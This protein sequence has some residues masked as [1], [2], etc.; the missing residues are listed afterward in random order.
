MIALRAIRVNKLRSILTTLGIIIGIVSVTAM[1]TVVNGIEN[2]FEEDMAELGTDVI[3]IERWP[4]VGGP[5]IKWWE[6]IN[7]PNITADL[8]RAVERRSKLAVAAA[9]VVRTSRTVRFG[10]RILNSV[11]I[12]GSTV[13]YPLVHTVDLASGFFYTAFDDRSARNV[14]VIGAGIADRLFPVEEP[15]GKVIS[16]SGSRYQVIGVMVRKGSGAEGPS[17]VDLEVKI[18]FNTFKKQFGTSR[19]DVSVQVKVANATLIEEAKD[20]LTGILRVARG[21]DAREDDDF[22][23]NEQQ[24]LRAQLAP[25]KAVIYSI[26]IGLT[27]LALLVGGIGVM[28]IMFVSVKERTREIGIRKAVGA[29]R[30]TILAQFLIEAV[31][32]CMVGGVVGVLLSLPITLLVQMIL[33]ATIDA[34]VVALAFGICVAIGTIFG[35]APAWTAAKAEP[36]QALRYE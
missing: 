11:T 6:Y 27:A 32:V 12:Q 7:R 23:I 34:G 17:G 19:R 14:C 20:E 22:T 25:I 8:A 26:G 21:L 31:V 3:Y 15:L 10:S 29:K 13:A 18:P 28:N 4:W 1:A 36:I 2:D 33:P 24:T 35:L 30:R 5:G 16:I 9:P